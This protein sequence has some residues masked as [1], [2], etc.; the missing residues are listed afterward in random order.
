MVIR[1]IHKID[2]LDLKL[3]T[4]RDELDDVRRGFCCKSRKGVMDGCVGA[5]D[6][7]LCMIN[8]P[9]KRF[10]CNVKEY[11][12]GHY[13]MY[14]INMQAMCDSEGKFMYCVLM[15]PGRSHDWPAYNA[16]NLKTWVEALPPDYSVVADNAYTGSTKL[17]VPF[18]G[19]QKADQGNSVF[20]F[21]LSQCQI[22]IERAFG[23]F[24]GKWGILQ[25]S[26]QCK[27]TQSHCWCLHRRTYLQTIQRCKACPDRATQVCGSR[28][29]IYPTI[30]AC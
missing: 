1:A 27:F 3:P 24:V 11:F 13:K 20:N 21:C 10:V 9:Q 30:C 23:M 16:T 18:Q 28:S 17:V 29:W 15:A 25:L 14:G 6:G 5:I 12:S 8:T 2:H 7:Y 22:N 4:T 19:Q 26:L